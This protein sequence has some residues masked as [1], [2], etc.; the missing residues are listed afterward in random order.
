MYIGH[1]RQL[2]LAPVATGSHVIWTSIYSLCSS[3]RKSSWFYPEYPP[4]GGF[5]TSILQL[6]IVLSDESNGKEKEKEQEEEE[7]VSGAEER[8]ETQLH[9]VKC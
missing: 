1:C 5:R 7:N 6:I 2:L 9:V 3:H 4:S 8:E